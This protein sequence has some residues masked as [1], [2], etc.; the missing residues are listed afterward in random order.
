M[1]DHKRRKIIKKLCQI[2]KIINQA[3]Y[4]KFIERFDLDSGLNWHNKIIGQIR[5]S[6][7]EVEDRKILSREF[8]QTIRD[9]IRENHTV[10]N[11]QQIALVYWDAHFDNILVKGNKIVGILDFERTELSSIDFVLDI[12]QR[13]SDYPQKYMAAEWEQY[14]KKE[15][16]ARLI[17][18]FQEFYPEL[19]QFK[20][21]DIRLDLY[22]IDLV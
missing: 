13:M 11:E 14:A 20:D 2:L 10:L 18:W 6:L 3:P 19:F 22:S 5:N 12:I 9:F 4:H 21:L 8:I 16:Y 15:D 1:D 17:N 7:R